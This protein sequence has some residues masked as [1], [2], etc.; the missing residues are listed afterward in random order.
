MKLEI[1][2]GYKVIITINANKIRVG[3]YASFWVR[4]SYLRKCV[5]GIVVEITNDTI[6]L[7][8]RDS[9]TCY[10]LT[11]IVED[12]NECEILSS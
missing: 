5:I 11:D 9:V 4:T 10:N 1:Y 6:S 12:N 2:D 3:D 8:Y 7:R